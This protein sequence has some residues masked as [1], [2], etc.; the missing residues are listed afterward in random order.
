M[1]PVAE[2]VD[3]LTPAWLTAALQAAGLDVTVAAVDAERV[4]TGQIGT[5]YRL[6]LTYEAGAG[7]GPATLVAKLPGGD[8]EARARVAGGYE[9][10]VGFYTELVA[11]VDVRTP[12]CWYGAISDDCSAFTLLLDDLTPARPGVQ[13]DGCTIEQAADA[14]RNVAGLHAP[15]WNDP[16]LYDYGFLTPVDA[17]TAA[18]LGEMLTV[19]TVQ[20][21]ARYQAE[22][23]AAD[24]ATLQEAARVI[25]DWQL[26]RPTPFSVIHGDYR[27]DN[28]MFPTTGEGV[29]AQIGRA[30]V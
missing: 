17:G 6:S 26:A 5:S 12:R 3:E 27:L 4:G 14:V 7:P 2:T 8:A 1:N 24:V 22:L 19:A 30:H 15:R 18:F 9:K 29:T 21:V 25:A 23:D 28:L 11:S 10:E 16:T 20:F 13:A